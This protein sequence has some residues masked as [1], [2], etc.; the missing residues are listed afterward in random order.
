MLAV[1]LDPKKENEVERGLTAG[2]DSHV[3][4]SV[5]HAFQHSSLI[6][7][8]KFRCAGHCHEFVTNSADQLLEFRN[9]FLEH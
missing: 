5:S 3:D 7:E 4:Q 8:L 9:L 2:G 1:D 6:R